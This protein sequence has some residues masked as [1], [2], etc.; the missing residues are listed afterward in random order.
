MIDKGLVDPSL[1]I[2]DES[3]GY[4]TR[5]LGGSATVDS[6][7]E[8]VDVLPDDRYLLCTDGLTTMIDD[9]SI[10]RILELQREP[11]EA[12]EHLVAAANAAGGED[13]VT[14]VIV[15]ARV[16]TPRRARSTVRW[17]T[18]LAIGVLILALALAFAAGWFDAFRFFGQASTAPSGA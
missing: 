10:A 12:A 4:I 7:V 15:D 9:P 6:D 2:V 14:V 16:Q 3:H 17:L 1:A 5:A 8:T 13:N 18:V 11:Q